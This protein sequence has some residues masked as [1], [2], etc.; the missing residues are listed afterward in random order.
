MYKDKIVQNSKKPTLAERKTTKPVYTTQ[1]K[2]YKN[3]LN[4]YSTYKTEQI[5]VSIYETIIISRRKFHVHVYLLNVKLL[6][7]IEN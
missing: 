2:R 1:G 5:L 7:I 4:P 3:I 6:K